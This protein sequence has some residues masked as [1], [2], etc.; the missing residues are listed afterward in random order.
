[1]AQIFRNLLAFWAA[2]GAPSGCRVSQSA[3][4][5]RRGAGIRLLTLLAMAFAIGHIP[6]VMNPAVSI[7]LWAGGRFPAK[8]L[9]PYIVSQVFGG[10]AAGS[11]LYLIASGKPGFDLSG[12][13]ASNG[14]GAHAPD[15]YSLQAALLTEV[16][17]TAMFLLVSLGATDRRAP[18][19]LA[20]IAIGLCLT[21]IHLIASGDEHLVE[22][23][24]H[25]RG[26][27]RRRLGDFQLW[28]P[29]APIVAHSVGARSIGSSAP[30][31]QPPLAPDRQSSGRQSVGATGCGPSNCSG[32]GC[33]GRK[34]GV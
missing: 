3:S 25:R 24:Q 8:D 4:V 34:K 7:G 13:F 15:G 17:M 30:R 12:G 22:P 10:I 31:R 9:V 32:K 5:S 16:V 29:V 20:P 21:L 11:I 19:G 1:M 23:A 27:A 6:A 28:L 14:Y 2:A 26:R 33:D 18:Q